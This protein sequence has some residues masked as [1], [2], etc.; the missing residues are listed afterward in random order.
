MRSRAKICA[1]S[2]SRGGVADASGLGTAVGAAVADGADV[3]VDAMAVMV[4]ADVAVDATVVMVG[5]DVAVA[6]TVVR[7]AAGA[8]VGAA[9]TSAAADVGVVARGDRVTSRAG[10]SELR[11][12]A[13]T[14]A[15]LHTMNVPAMLRIT[16]RIHFL[17]DV[18]GGLL[19]VCITILLD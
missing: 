4:G 2:T 11:T 15:Q 17:G 8:R 7:V 5:A 1:A 19:G 12:T 14:Q 16:Q 6:A 9:A 3:A 18:A 13:P 10:N